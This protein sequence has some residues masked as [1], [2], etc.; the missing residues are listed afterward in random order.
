MAIYYAHFVSPIGLIDIAA[1]DEGL[2]FVN[3]SESDIP[4][5]A[6]KHSEDTQATLR[7][8]EEYFAGNR[9]SFEL[10]LA[11]QGTPFQKQVWD[12]LMHIPFGKT[13]SYHDIAYRMNNLGAIRAVGA[14][15]GNNKI[16][17]IVPCHRVIG[18]NGQLTGY[19]GG[20]HRK[21]WLLRHE[22]AIPQGSLF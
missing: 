11:P 13:V 16:A 21:E 14:A 17:I 9:K 19:A 10:K 20:L 6:T 8:L 15:N 3:F 2:V 1:S 18:A 5:H 4:E 7:Q 22:N 12:E